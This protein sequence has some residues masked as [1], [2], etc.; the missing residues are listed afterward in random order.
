MIDPALTAELLAL[1]Q[2]L[3]QPAVRHDAVALCALLASDF[4]EFGSSGRVYDREAIVAALAAEQNDT[5]P[6]LHLA[7]VTGTALAAETVLLTYRCL[8][9][10][11]TASL[12]SSIWVRCDG[13]WQMLFHQG[14]RAAEVAS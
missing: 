3:L 2:R 8:R 10:D 4:R 12:R 1:E 6:P 14:T 9:P 11:G 7:D 5:A 13:R